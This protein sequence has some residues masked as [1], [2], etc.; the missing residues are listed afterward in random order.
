[1][2]VLPGGFAVVAG[3]LPQID[4]GLHDEDR[5]DVAAYDAQK[6]GV[7]FGKRLLRI[8]QI[9]HRICGRQEA[10]RHP[11]MGGIDRGESGRV[12]DEEAPLEK[13][14]VGVDQHARRGVRFVFGRVVKRTGLARADR[15]EAIEAIERNPFAAPVF[16]DRRRLFVRRVV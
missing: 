11:T 12:G 16:E 13:R 10:E 8:D 5:I 14:R 7:A 4:L 3:L 6:L 9:E 1:M 15:D 2:R